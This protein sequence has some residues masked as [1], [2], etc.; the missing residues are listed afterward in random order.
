MEFTHLKG[1][2]PLHWDGF[3]WNGWIG[4]ARHVLIEVQKGHM[5]PEH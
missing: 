5:T 4:G 1:I 3:V 2:N